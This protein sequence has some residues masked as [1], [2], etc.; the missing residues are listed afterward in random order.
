V[1]ETQ[2]S[3]RTLGD[4]VTFDVA[5]SKDQAQ[6]LMYVAD[7]ADHRNLAAAP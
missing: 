5:F 2:I 1:K 6:R 4:G 7:G 3:R